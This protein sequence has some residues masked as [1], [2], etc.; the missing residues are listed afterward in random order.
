MEVSSPGSPLA[1]SSA[2]ADDDVRV[3]EGSSFSDSDDSS[4]T[5]GV[6]ELGA[7]PMSGRRS[8]KFILPLK[9]LWKASS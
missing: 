9:Y 8:D 5:D 6:G 1:S 7:N 2:L 3:G 4:V